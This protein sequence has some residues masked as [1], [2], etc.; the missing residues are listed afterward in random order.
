MLGSIQSYELKYKN[1]F[2]KT[3]I[4]LYYKRYFFNKY[5]RVAHASP[6]VRNKQL[7]ICLRDSYFDF[8]MRKQSICSEKQSPRLDYG[9]ERITWITG[10]M[11]NLK[12]SYRHKTQQQDRNMT[13]MY[14]IIAR[15]QVKGEHSFLL[16]DP[17]ITV[18]VLI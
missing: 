13:N 11:T 4:H 2:L 1:W 9:S 17:M 10:C 8:S 5:V 18:L 3:L 15:M 14:F 6:L 12:K 7:R 16:L